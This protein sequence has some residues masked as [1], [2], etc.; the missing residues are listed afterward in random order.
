ML[1]RPVG[2]GLLRAVVLIRFTV[3]IFALSTATAQALDLPQG[4]VQQ[5]SEAQLFDSYDLPLGPWG[6][7][8][9]PSRSVEGATT[10][11]AWQIRA[12]ALSTLQLIRPL[13]DQLQEAGFDILFECQ[14]EACGGFDFRFG[15]ETLPPPQMQVNLGDFRFLTAVQNLP[16][17]D[18][19][20]SLLVSRTAQS[21][22]VQIIRVTPVADIPSDVT[23]PAVAPQN[24]VAAGS[25]SL[26]GQLDASGRAI[27]SDLDFATGSAT[28]SVRPFE[29]LAELAGYLARYPD[30]NV[31]LVGHT[32]ATGAL[33][34]N[35]ALSRQRAAAVLD[36]LVADHGVARRQLA[37]EGM[38]Y[39]A[40][41][42]SNLTA[43]GRDANRRVEVIITSID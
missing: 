42:A 21:G 38:G 2:S 29:S 17:G 36:R 31:A 12:S 30:R 27:L 1:R 37:A 15:T 5:A 39:L 25:S 22:Y 26:A 11:E 33:A 16:D 6:G 19:Y 24:V 32:D 13:R 23:A 4:A 9:V 20:L 18:G 35:I 41:V 10:R 43:E 14:T 8:V 3:L 28:L 7:G 40:P 34:P